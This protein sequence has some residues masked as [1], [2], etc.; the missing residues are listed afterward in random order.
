MMIKQ[1]SLNALQKALNHA[2]SLDE[3]TLKKIKRLHEKVLEI[4]ITPLNVHFFIRFI[5]EK[6]E[7]LSFYAGTPDTVIHSSPLGLIRLSLLP[8]SKVR[9]L[10]NDRIRISGD[11]ALG[12]DV[13]RLFDEINI[14]WEGHLAHF[15]GDVVAHQVG[16]FF[17]QGLA[18]KRR[19]SQTMQHN[20][21]EYLQ[22]EIRLCPPR[23]ALDDFFSDID[24]LSLRVERLTAHINQ[25]LA[26][27]ETH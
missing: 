21:A 2:L 16:S 9:S 25:L 11:I 17:R 13:K 20:V 26:T 12:Q 27:H 19:I 4:I 1:H 18:F 6:V 3:S 15:T 22:E 10:F 8:S 23:E 5:D 14:D 7:L 24:D